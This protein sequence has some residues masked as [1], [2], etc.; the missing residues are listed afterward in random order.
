MKV[1]DRFAPDLDE[2]PTLEVPN[3]RRRAQVLL[4]VMCGS[5]LDP[6][7]YVERLEIVESELR[8]VY[9]E[10]VALVRA[11]TEY[12]MKMAQ[13][14]LVPPTRRPA[15]TEPGIGPISLPPPPVL[16]KVGELEIDWS[17]FNDE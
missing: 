12:Q 10:T 16:P 17:D 7:D 8:Q 15:K 1:D 9:Q 2:H 14:Q 3:F 4:H 11:Q 13:E 6:Q 5:D